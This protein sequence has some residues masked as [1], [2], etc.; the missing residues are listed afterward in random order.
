LT[1]VSPIL[2]IDAT[3]WKDAESTMMRDRQ[4][5]LVALAGPRVR[6][7][8]REL[9]AVDSA[10]HLPDQ[11]LAR[12]D[13]AV[14]AASLLTQQLEQDWRSLIPWPVDRIDPMRRA[15]RMAYVSVG[16]ATASLVLAPLWIGAGILLLTGL[17]IFWT[18]KGRARRIHEVALKVE[19]GINARHSLRRLE[20]ELI[21]LLTLD[22]AHDA[23]RL[24]IAQLRLQDDS[25]LDAL[26]QLAPLRDRHPDEGLVVVL[27][28]VAYAR[29]GAESDAARMLSA[30]KID[31]EHPW[32]ERLRTFEY[33][34]QNAT[35]SRSRVAS[36]D[37]E[38][39][40]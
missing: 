32:N 34:C 11:Q 14:E 40:M 9:G 39:D 22:P 1:H 26:L 31:P 37:P 20:P 16:V 10:H 30:L 35:E 5:N 8:K 36:E 12:A 15:R 7:P 33:V 29:L 38:V 19:A 27:A 25:P 18:L 23:A 24:L 2:L 4:D 28:A 13:S 6:S 21:E 3:L 17:G